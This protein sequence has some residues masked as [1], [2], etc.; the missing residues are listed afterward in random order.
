MW[1]LTVFGA[2]AGRCERKIKMCGEEKRPVGGNWPLRGSQCTTIVHV[3][4]RYSGSEDA[5]RL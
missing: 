5:Q 1:P 3:E 2:W 4:H